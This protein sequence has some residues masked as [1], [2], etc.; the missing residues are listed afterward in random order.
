MTDAEFGHLEIG[1]Y[2]SIAG[3]VQIIVANHAVDRVTTYPFAALHRIWPSAPA[4]RSDHT[5]DGVV[6]GHDVWIGQGVTIL[7]GARIG[8]GA[9]VGAAAVVAKAVPPFAGVVGNPA[10]VTRRRFDDGTIERLLAVAW[11]HWPDEKV[12]RFV[13]LLLAGDVARFL[14]RAE[15]SV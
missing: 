14:E 15:A 13:P 7:P 11:W 2:C 4:D 6:I 3:N 10:R 8:D 12:D 5:G 1:R 9:I